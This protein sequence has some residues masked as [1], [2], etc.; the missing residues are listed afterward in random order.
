MKKLIILLA[1]TIFLGGMALGPLGCASHHDK[2]LHS[3]KKSR[4]SD[5]SKQREGSGY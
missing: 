1:L 2:S 5:Y 3:S 4:S